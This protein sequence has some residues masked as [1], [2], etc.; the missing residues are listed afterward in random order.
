MKNQSLFYNKEK[1]EGAAR[2]DVS[3]PQPGII[4]IKEGDNLGCH[5]DTTNH[6][7]GKE[8]D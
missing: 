7:K 3:K 6:G 4:I 5:Y 2:Y 8:K 1:L